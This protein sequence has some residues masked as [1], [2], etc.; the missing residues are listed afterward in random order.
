MTFLPANYEPPVTSGYM[1]L[2]DGRNR[3]RVLGPA[4]VGNEFWKTG[5]DNKRIPVRRRMNEPIHAGELPVD[6][7]S[8]KAE[9]IRHFWAFPVW[10]YNDE[11]VQILQLTQATIQRAVRALCDDPEW[12]DPTTY[13]LVITRSG[14]ELDT[15]YT[16]QPQPRKNLH[17][18]VTAAFAATPINLEALFD[19][20]DPFLAGEA[21]PPQ[22][23]PAE[24]EQG[25][26]LTVTLDQVR[27]RMAKGPD[28]RPLRVLEVTWNNQVYGSID[29]ALVDAVVA[30]QGEV[31]RL[32][33]SKSARGGRRIDRF[34]R[35][36]PAPA[37]APAIGTPGTTGSPGA[38]D[39]A[40][41]GDDIPF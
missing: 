10:N 21:P 12:G 24:D 15:E 22:A 28:G 19:G 41:G 39:S 6:A 25:G 8:G 34:D 2:I 11:R 40:S 5:P 23:P 20:G 3:L 18:D 30:A 33:W 13:D 32:T 38:A 37:P 16:V 35:E 4:I 27:E 9:R 29:P 14:S 1:K 36:K 7:R 17:P 31:A 26:V